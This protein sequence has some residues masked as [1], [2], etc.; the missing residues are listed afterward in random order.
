MVFPVLGILN[1]SNRFTVEN[2]IAQQ[3]RFLILHRQHAPYHRRR[4]S[5][6]FVRILT[7]LNILI[8]AFGLVVPSKV[9]RI[10]AAGQ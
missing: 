5:I 3:N 9:L 6:F 10:S 7:Q 4:C 2:H 1:K 8:T